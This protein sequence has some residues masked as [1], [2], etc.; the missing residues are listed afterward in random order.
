MVTESYKNRVAQDIADRSVNVRVN[1]DTVIPI[2]S[3]EVS[4]NT[5]KLSTQRVDDFGGFS[6]VEL[7]DADG[8]V[9]YR[10]ETSLPAISGLHSQIQFEFEVI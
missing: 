2:I 10:R 7:L 6:L 4:R 9:I 8:S 1:G 3:R 5:V